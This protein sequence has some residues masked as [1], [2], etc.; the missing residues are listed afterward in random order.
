MGQGKPQIHRVKML[1]SKGNYI[2]IDGDT[3]RA[4]TR[5]LESYK[6]NIGVE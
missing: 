2:V 1:E 3:Y 6:R 4:H 5:I